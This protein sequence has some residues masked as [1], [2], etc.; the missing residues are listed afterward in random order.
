MYA[1]RLNPDTCFPDIGMNTRHVVG[2]GMMA[3]QFGLFWRTEYDR[4]DKGLT[5]SS[6]L[7]T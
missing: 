2:F 7:S 6:R 5:F 3:T 4:K 1:Q